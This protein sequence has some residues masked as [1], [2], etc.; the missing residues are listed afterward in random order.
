MRRFVNGL[1][2]LA[3]SVAVLLPLALTGAA[4][5]GFPHPAAAQGLWYKEVEK[6]GRIYVF[7]TGVQLEMWQK[8]GEIGNKAVTMIG[9][10][11]NGE[12]VVAE[13]SFLNLV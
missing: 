1:G 4:L 10:G 3:L 12:T 13:S 2:A 9:Q 5:L 6:D 7:N 11:P 8:S